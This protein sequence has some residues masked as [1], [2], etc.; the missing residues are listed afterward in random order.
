M[1]SI[2]LSPRVFFPDDSAVTAG[3]RSDDY[4]EYP[5]KLRAAIDA[6]NAVRNLWYP[7]CGKSPRKALLD[8]LIPRAKD[9]GLVHPDNGRLNMKGID[10]VVS[11]ANWDP[12]G[13][14]PKTRYGNKN[15]L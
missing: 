8:W 14:A 3:N 6:N 11:V 1:R 10:E 7:D 2:K 12:K 4:K 5:S 13:G 9:Y 15:T